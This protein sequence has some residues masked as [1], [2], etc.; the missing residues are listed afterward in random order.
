LRVI[1]PYVDLYPETRAA[2]EADGQTP[3]YV[4]VRGSPSAYH[5]MLL[6]VWS[7][8]QGFT[9]VE[10]DIVVRPG[11][12]AELEACPEPWCASVYPISGGFI[13]GLGH[14]RFSHALVRERTAVIER[15][16]SLPFDGTPRRYWGRL[17]TR[18][19]QSLM[20]HESLRVHRHLPPLRHLNP[21]QQPPIFNCVKCGAAAPEEDMLEAE[22][23]YTCRQCGYDPRRPTEG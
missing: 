19:G 23:P 3:E 4:D 2:L 8:G 12:I 1:V 15:I 5:E 6:R 20:D 21:V 11:R 9:V 13:T 16:D 18:V 17:D 14:V 22:P 10:Q 7:E